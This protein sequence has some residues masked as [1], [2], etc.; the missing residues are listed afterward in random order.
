MFKLKACSMNGAFSGEPYE[1]EMQ[2]VTELVLSRPRGGRGMSG[3][4]LLLGLDDLA[5]ATSLP[6]SSQSPVSGWV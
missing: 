2:L 3:V 4:E 5:G 1:G 6:P